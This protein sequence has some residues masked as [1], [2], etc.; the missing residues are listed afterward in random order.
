M[1]SVPL[2]FISVFM[3]ISRCFKCCGSVVKFTVRDCDAFRSSLIVQDFRIVQ[4]ILSFVFLMKLRI[5]LSRSVKNFAIILIC[6]ESA[7]CFWVAIHKV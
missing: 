2:A 7:E 1:I 3:P 5:V 4:V 6:I